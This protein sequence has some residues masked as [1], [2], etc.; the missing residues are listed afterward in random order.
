MA[1]IDYILSHPDFNRWFWSYTKSADLL[2][3]H[4]KALADSLCYKIT[5]SRELHPA[6]R[7]K[8]QRDYTLLILKMS[9]SFLDV[10]GKFAIISKKETP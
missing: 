6:L 8:F 1:I 2:P 5:A 10:L 4:V 3:L 9:H 7:N